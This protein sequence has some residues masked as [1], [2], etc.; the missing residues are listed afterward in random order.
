MRK[1]LE[2]AQNIRIC[3][4]YLSIMRDVRSIAIL[5]EYYSNIQ[6]HI[7]A[8]AYMQGSLAAFQTDHRTSLEL[9]KLSLLS[10]DK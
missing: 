2:Y 4:K 9:I 5:G 8:Q 3:A 10:T 1:I 6:I 7:F